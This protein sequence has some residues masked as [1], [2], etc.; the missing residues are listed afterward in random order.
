MIGDFLGGLFGFL[1]YLFC[2][3]DWWGSKRK[4]DEKRPAADRP[5]YPDLEPR[6]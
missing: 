5:H 4:N 3:V 2:L 1:L 6:Q